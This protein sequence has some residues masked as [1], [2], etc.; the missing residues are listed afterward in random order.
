MKNPSSLW[1][2]VSA[3]VVAV[4]ILVCFTRGVW[5]LWL[6]LTVFALWGV[7]EVFRRLLP[8][9][10]EYLGSRKAHRKNRKVRHAPVEDADLLCYRRR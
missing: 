1:P 5:Q 6:L 9:L 7:W 3:L 4:L 8:F 10:Q 2:D